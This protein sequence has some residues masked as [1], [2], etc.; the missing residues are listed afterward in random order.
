MGIPSLS[1]SLALYPALPSLLIS[2]GG[3]AIML[4]GNLSKVS[5]H[6]VALPLQSFQSGTH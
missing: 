2:T 4:Y 1:L 6:Y 3:H 5:E